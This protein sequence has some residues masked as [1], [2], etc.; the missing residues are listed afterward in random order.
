MIANLEA[1]AFVGEFITCVVVDR[2]NFPLNS[3]PNIPQPSLYWKRN[4]NTG[5]TPVSDP[6]LHTTLKFVIFVEFAMRLFLLPFIF[7]QSPLAFFYMSAHSHGRQG[8]YRYCDELILCSVLVLIVNLVISIIFTH[9]LSA[10]KINDI[11]IIGC[12]HIRVWQYTACSS[13]FDQQRFIFT[14]C[15]YI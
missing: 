11:V 8:I 3:L 12:C 5:N 15:V 14:T 1:N 7:R 10:R 4:R 6:Y 13:S 2:E 9:R